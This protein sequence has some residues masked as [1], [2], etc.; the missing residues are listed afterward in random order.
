MDDEI[1]KFNFKYFEDWFDL[2]V[3]EVCNEKIKV[4]KMRIVECFGESDYGY[5]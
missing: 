1:I 5:G 4:K 2:K 3:F